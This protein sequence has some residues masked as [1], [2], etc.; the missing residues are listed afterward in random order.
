MAPGTGRRATRFEAGNHAGTTAFGRLREPRGNHGP[1][2]RQPRAG[3]TPGT[4]RNHPRRHPGNHRGGIYRNP[5][6]SRARDR[7]PRTGTLRRPRRGC[8]VTTS[9]LPTLLTVADVAARYGFADRRAARALM[10]RAGAFR[11]GGRVF[12]R[13]DDLDAFERA[14]ADAR[15]RQ[16]AP[17]ARASPRRRSSSQAAERWEGR[18]WRK[19]ND[20]VSCIKPFLRKSA[21][22][23]ASPWRRTPY[24]GTVY[25][26]LGM[27]VLACVPASACRSDTS[28]QEHGPRIARPDLAHH[29]CRP[30]RSTTTP[31]SS[32]VSPRTACSATSRT[33]PSWPNVLS[34]VSNL[35]HS[36][37]S[38]HGSPE[39]GQRHDASLRASTDFDR[40]RWTEQHWR[41]LLRPDPG[42]QIPRSTPAPRA[43]A[44][45][46]LVARVRE[47]GFLMGALRT[48]LQSGTR[49]RGSAE[50]FGP[51][52]VAGAAVAVPGADHRP[53]RSVP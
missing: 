42:R 7:R 23:R 52:L 53:W 10:D 45:G 35:H 47:R 27:R 14:Q 17:T 49:A 37:A 25:T 8:G 46:S 19:P 39:A 4:T 51:G 13:A 29:R 26:V 22:W 16:E 32:C 15:R 9:P 34:T 40:R 43:G 41:R 18:W 24:S 12:V 48:D 33:A 20:G 5:P 1:K 28:R 2:T 6:W 50:R 3:T 31:A 30:A 11:V 38:L 36:Q 21:R 44:A